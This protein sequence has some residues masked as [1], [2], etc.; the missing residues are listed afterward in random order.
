M[1]DYDKEILVKL[2]S[3]NK[4]TYQ[5]IRSRLSHLSDSEIQYADDNPIQLV[6]IPREYA[7]Y[8]FSPDDRFKLTEYGENLLHRL[9]RDEKMESIATHS[10]IYAEKSYKATVY[11]GIISI[12]IS[13]AALALSLCSIL[14]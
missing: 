3:Q 7:I 10:A 5:D 4:N 13:V 9:Q 12:A 1:T 14:K 6:N 11:I 8:N 2:I